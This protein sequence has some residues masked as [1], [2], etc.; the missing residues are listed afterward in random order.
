MSGSASAT[1]VAAAMAALREV[2]GLS[3]VHEEMPIQAAAPHA[4]VG[5]GLETDWSH[6]SGA[7]RELR[8]SVILR[9]QSE[10]PGR[11]RA[12]AAKA[13]AALQEMPVELDGWRLVTLVFV[14]S[15]TVAE[16]SGRWALTLD[17]RARML[18][19]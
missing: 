19:A 11:L 15:M 18:A 13:E 1:L 4:M 2:A 5:A 8:L 7:G 10:R 12:L 16:S 9:D 14:R 6:K 17:Y 3:G